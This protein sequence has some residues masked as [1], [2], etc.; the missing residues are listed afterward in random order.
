MRFTTQKLLSNPRN[1]HIAHLYQNGGT[2][3]R[4]HISER[5]RIVSACTQSTHTLHSTYCCKKMIKR[6]NVEENLCLMNEFPINIYDVFM[7][8]FY[9]QIKV[10][11]AYKTGLQ[12]QRKAEGYIKDRMFHIFPSTVKSILILSPP[13]MK[14]VSV[15]KNYYSCHFRYSKFV[16]YSVKFTTTNIM[17][18]VFPHI[19]AAATILF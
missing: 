4:T 18:T 8:F 17:H 14:Y 9:N 7:K 3:S 6:E 16:F 2:S 15:I 12:C 10:Q 13:F 19:V 11:I 5:A 1:F